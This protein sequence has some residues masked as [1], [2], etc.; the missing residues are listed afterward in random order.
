MDAASVECQR[1]CRSC[2]LD[3]GTRCAHLD[4]PNDYF[5]VWMVL[6]ARRLQV[7][8]VWLYVLFAI[9]IAISVT[10]PLFLYA[11]EHRLAALQAASTEPQPS[12]SDKLGLGFLT[13]GTVAFAL[14][15]TLR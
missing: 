5:S 2:V 14:W 11:R 8:N 10:F 13:V 12:T 3:G 6:E 15:C 9:T 4:A 1:A 7:R